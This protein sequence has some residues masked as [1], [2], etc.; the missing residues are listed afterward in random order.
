VQRT[1]KIIE[2]ELKL[3]NRAR[4]RLERDLLRATRTLARFGIMARCEEMKGQPSATRVRDACRKSLR[5][6]AVTAK[7]LE[8]ELLALQTPKDDS[9]F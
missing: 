4:R 7:E 5:I 1:P 3:A 8:A 9:E 2:R 6:L